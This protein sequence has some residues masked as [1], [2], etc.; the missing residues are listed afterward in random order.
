MAGVEDRPPCR[1]RCDT[2]QKDNFGSLGFS[3]YLQVRLSAH[4]GLILLES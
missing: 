1:D 2:F 4:S 3:L